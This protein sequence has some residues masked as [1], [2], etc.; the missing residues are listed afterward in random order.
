MPR[1]VANYQASTGLALEALDTCCNDRK[2]SDR[3][4]EDTQAD[5][6]PTHPFSS[7]PG[8]DG[9]HSISPVWGR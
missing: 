2:R 9:S 5:E 1:P 8:D 4:Y 7:P 6:G 3:R